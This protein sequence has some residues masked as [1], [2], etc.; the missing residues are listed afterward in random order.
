MLER[1]YSCIT[2]SI[3]FG[4]IYGGLALFLICLIIASDKLSTVNGWIT[5]DASLTF[6]LLIVFIVCFIFIITLLFF[7]IN[8]LILKTNSLVY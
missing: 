1:L 5:T 3:L 4:L 6:I 2:H 7:I 8:K